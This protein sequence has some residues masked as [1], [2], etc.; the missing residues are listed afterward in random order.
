[1]FEVPNKPK[2]LPMKFCS[3][4]GDFCWED[5]KEQAKKEYPV[6]YFLSETIPHVFAV[7]VKIPAEM[8]YYKWYSKLIK[9]QH[10]LDLRQFF[11]NEYEYGY[12]SGDK[13]ILY[14]C[15]N[16][17]VYYVEKECGGRRAFL[18]EI[19]FQESQQDKTYAEALK[20]I[21]EIYDWWT[22][23]RPRRKWQIYKTEDSFDPQ[24]ESELEE[25]ED[26]MLKKILLVRK[27]LWI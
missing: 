4:P 11:D 14:A 16:T 21:L 25:K 22:I 20:Q 2:A 6:R 1:M 13:K 24:L 3:K 7:K 26:E 8:F 23:D 27:F 18:E 19:D 5:W 12:I 9:K 10:L 15:F 17:I